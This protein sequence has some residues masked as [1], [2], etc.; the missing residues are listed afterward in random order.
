M[1]AATRELLDGP[2]CEPGEREGFTVVRCTSS[3]RGHVTFAERG[4]E[5]GEK[6]LLRALLRWTQMG[7]DVC[8]TGDGWTV[9]S[10]HPGRFPAGRIA[11]TAPRDERESGAPAQCNSAL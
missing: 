10:H 9:K 5:V 4:E 6:C 3:I 1:R 8:C 2:G 11:Y 7:H